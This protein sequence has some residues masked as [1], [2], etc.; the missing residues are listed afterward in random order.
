MFPPAPFPKSDWIGIASASLC[1][2]HCLLTPMLVALAAT[3]GWWPGLPY[4]F[5]MISGYAAIETSRHSNGSPWLWLIWTSLLVLTAAIIF[6][7]EAEWLEWTSYLASVGLVVGHVL[8]MA[9]C[10]KCRSQQQRSS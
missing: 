5:L 7:E 4:L 2:V 8:N 10:R 9:Y 3:Y 6:E 1:V